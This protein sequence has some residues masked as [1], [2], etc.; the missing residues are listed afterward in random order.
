[1][2]HETATLFAGKVSAVR[3]GN[4]ALFLTDSRRSKTIKRS[5]CAGAA[6]GIIRFGRLSGTETDVLIECSIVLRRSK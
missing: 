2:Y 5:F 6:C 4:F 3:H 1:M